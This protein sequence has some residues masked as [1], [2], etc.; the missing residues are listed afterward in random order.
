[1]HSIRPHQTFVG[2]GGFK[3]MYPLFEKSWGSNLNIY[4]KSEIWKYLFKILRTMMNI[5]PA[6]IH[7]LFKNKNLI[8]ILK[9]CLIRSGQP[10]CNLLTK[11]LLSEVMKIIHDIRENASKYELEGF[12]K[13]F[14]YDIILSEAFCSLKFS[15]NHRI[16]RGNLVFTEV[17]DSL[18]SIFMN[19]PGQS[20]L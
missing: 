11:E 1:V 8:D 16:E 5:E 10:K 13:R 17:A 3:L 19:A 15:G 2:L 20:S 9:Y 7:R 6:H 18:H 4:Q 14:L 12:Y